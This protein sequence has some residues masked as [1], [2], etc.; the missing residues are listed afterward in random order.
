M[1][2]RSHNRKGTVLFVHISAQRGR[3]RRRR[4]RPYLPPVT[5]AALRGFQ[6]DTSPPR[7]G[8][9]GHLRQPVL[10]EPAVGGG[11]P[12][13]GP[14]AGERGRGGRQPRSG[15]CDG[16]GAILRG[17]C[18]LHGED[19]EA[20]SATRERGRGPQVLQGRELATESK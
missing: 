14:G 15:L 20:G 7:L 2:R 5:A 12:A 17:L 13:V 1:S 19:G 8:H 3:H 6:R 4:R 16:P 11:A 9:A 10:R 18:G